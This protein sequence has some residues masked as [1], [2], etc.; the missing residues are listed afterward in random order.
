MS[1]L[2]KRLEAALSNP[3]SVKHLDLRGSADD[4]LEELPKE[5]GSLTALEH[6]DL[7]HNALRALPQQIEQLAN[8]AVLDVR[9]NQLEAMPSFEKLKVLREVYFGRN[10]IVEIDKHFAW[11]KQLQ[12]FEAHGNR[13]RYIPYGFSP[14]A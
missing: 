7:S 8:L 13:I 2:K 11:M 4:R 12:R 3:S 9:D 14:S 5:I 10:R 6:L 1:A